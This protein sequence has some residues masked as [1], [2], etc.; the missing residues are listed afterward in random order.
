[1]CAPS[2]PLRP[3]S[4]VFGYTLFECVRLTPGQASLRRVSRPLRPTDAYAAPL[5]AV[6]A[7][8]IVDLF[9]A[10]DELRRVFV[11]ATYE[12]FCARVGR[13]WPVLLHW[14]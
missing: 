10:S 14:H 5:M 2:R 8:E 6:S 13:D 4:E 7:G 3:P 11:S 12:D 9:G 1:M